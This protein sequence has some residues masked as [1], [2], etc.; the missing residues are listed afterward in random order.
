[1]VGASSW[2]TKWYDLCVWCFVRP[3]ELTGR[4]EKQVDK[5]TVVQ[6]LQTPGGLVFPFG[7]LGKVTG[8][9]RNHST[10]KFEDGRWQI[11]NGTLIEVQA[12]E[13]RACNCA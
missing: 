3:G 10:C 7:Q 13:P 4:P 2:S 11:S 1:M 6:G 8:A 12:F 9:T 5:W